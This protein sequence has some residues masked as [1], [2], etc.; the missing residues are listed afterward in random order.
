MLNQLGFVMQS[1]HFLSLFI[2]FHGLDLKALPLQ[3]SHSLV[4]V[5]HFASEILDLQPVA[6]NLLHLEE[7]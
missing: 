5:Q 6:V 4:D 1:F 7:N 3:L 2:N